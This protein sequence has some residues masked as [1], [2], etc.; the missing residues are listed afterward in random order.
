MKKAI[1]NLH[2]QFPRFNFKLPLPSA[3]IYRR[4]HSLQLAPN[5]FPQ[6]GDL[7]TPNGHETISPAKLAA[8]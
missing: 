5:V 8:L 6:I 7:S 4:C 1:V 2:Q 3:L